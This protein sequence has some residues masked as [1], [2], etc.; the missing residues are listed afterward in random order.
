VGRRYLLLATCLLLA[1]A[2]LVY[3][4]G[5][6]SGQREMTQAYNQGLTLWEA[7]E[8]PRFLQTR[9]L[10]RFN[11]TEV[12]LTQNVTAARSSSHALAPHSS[13]A[14]QLQDFY[15][16]ILSAGEMQ[17]LTEAQPA[18][19]TGGNVTGDVPQLSARGRVGWSAAAVATAAAAAPSLINNTVELA[20]VARSAGPDDV[21]PLGAH[22][23]V[24]SVLRPTANWKTCKH[25]MHGIVTAK[26]A[27]LLVDVLHR[28]CIRVKRDP[29]SDK[30]ILA[31]DL[32]TAG[33]GPHTSR[34]AL[35][36]KSLRPPTAPQPAAGVVPKQLLAT[37]QINVHS[38]LDPLFLGPVLMQKHGQ[39]SVGPTLGYI[40]LILGTV[41]LV[42]GI[43]L[44]LPSDS[45]LDD[46]DGN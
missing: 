36:Y 28:I 40:C 12:E 45:S 9:W 37:S 27:C 7:R 22:P 35:Q 39:Q 33:C 34:T 30:W 29:I 20:L 8:R 46:T 3:S 43:C 13:V 42:P 44:M 16:H 32:G 26:K 15:T 25:R 1:G 41:L 18:D 31:G 5:G 6:S 24:R 2:Y 19:L 4:S 14:F 21:I 10:M 38:D 17:T 11:G 23:L